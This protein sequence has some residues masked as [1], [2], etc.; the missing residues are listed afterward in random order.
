MLANAET[1]TTT[2]AQFP[3]ID[4]KYE[5]AP[6]ETPF[7]AIDGQMLGK[8]LQEVGYGTSIISPLVIAHKT[9]IPGRLASYEPVG[10]DVVISQDGVI[11]AL[12]ILREKEHNYLDGVKGSRLMHLLKIIDG[13]LNLFSLPHRTLRNRGRV[14]FYSGN[15]QRREEYLAEAKKGLFRITGE[16]GVKI[17]L[18]KE[19]SVKR[20][21][22]VIDS[23]IEKATPGLIGWL[24][25]HEFEHK[26]KIRT[27]KAIVFGLTVSPLV[28]A[29]SIPGVPTEGSLLLGFLGSFI[30]VT[31]GRRMEE[32]ASYDVADKNIHSFAKAI[33]I[34][35]Q[36]F[37]EKVLGQIPT[38][39]K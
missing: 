5:L 25:A 31:L 17:N 26:N 10:K 4:V 16:E 28:A 32:K 20:A 34:N 3:K 2:E 1:G 29:A 30:G 37:Q 14:H 35:H 23:L 19:E 18:S 39:T 22:Q 27:K 36:M 24:I 15:L 11:T 7:I 33:Q 13:Y 9:T 38:V 8:A 21:K 6:G 12:K